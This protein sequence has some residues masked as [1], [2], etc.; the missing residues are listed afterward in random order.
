MAT[1]TIPKIGFALSFNPLFITGI[2]FNVGL[3]FE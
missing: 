1:F 2:N 3:I